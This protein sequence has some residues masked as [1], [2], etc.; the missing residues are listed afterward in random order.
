MAIIL[1][2]RQI[3]EN[4]IIHKPSLGSR[5]IPQKNL[6]PIGS[7]VLTFIGYKQTDRQA[8]FIYR[9]RNP[10]GLKFPSSFLEVQS[11][12]QNITVDEFKIVFIG[13]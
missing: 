5:E 11:V 4:L 9:R 13:R 10:N 2:W 12:P 6:G 8:K 1:F 3:F 7:A